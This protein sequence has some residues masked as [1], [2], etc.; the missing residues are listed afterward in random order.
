V[1][2]TVVDKR[3]LDFIERSLPYYELNE[4][5]VKRLFVHAGV[6]EV[7]CTEDI[8]RSL[9]LEDV[10]PVDFLWTRDTA[11]DAYNHAESPNYTFG[12]KYDN[13]YIGHTPRQK[14]NVFY[15]APQHWGNIWLMDTGA[16]FKG[17]LSIMDIDTEQTWQSKAV[18]GYYPDEKGRNEKSYNEV[19]F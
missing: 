18:N 13:I 12:D 5:G 7:C 16:C 1:S 14:L 10:D 6:P 8:D 17:Q 11:W 2:K 4:K 3:Y 9:K 19:N 15:S